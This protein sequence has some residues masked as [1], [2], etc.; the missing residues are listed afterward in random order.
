[1]TRQRDKGMPSLTLKHGDDNKQKRKN[2]WNVYKTYK[3]I[4]QLPVNQNF[5]K[6]NQKIKKQIPDSDYLISPRNE[7]LGCKHQYDM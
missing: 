5:C 6:Q 2:N 1:M 4:K 7:N 3:K